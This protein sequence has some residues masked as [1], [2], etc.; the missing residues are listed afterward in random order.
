MRS[1]TPPPLKKK[2]PLSLPKSLSCTLSKART[3]RHPRSF[4]PAASADSPRGGAA[5][6][7]PGSADGGGGAVMAA[8]SGAAEAL[9]LLFLWFAALEGAAGSEPPLKCEELRLGQYPERGWGRIGRGCGGDGPGVMGGGAPLVG[10]GRGGGD[11]EVPG[12]AGGSWKASGRE[13]RGGLGWQERDRAPQGAAFEG[14]ASSCASG[15]ISPQ[16]G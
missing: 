5:P 8:R 10:R 16:K 4:L 14:T 6:L 9:L 7:L 1:P 15:G 3:L 13:P 12:R 11:R 2:K